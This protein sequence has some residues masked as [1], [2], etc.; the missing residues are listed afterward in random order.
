M[1]VN[2]FYRQLFSLYQ[3][4]LNV[5]LFSRKCHSLQENAILYEG[6]VIVYGNNVSIDVES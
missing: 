6:F 4:K 5:P 1:L 2:P 3:S